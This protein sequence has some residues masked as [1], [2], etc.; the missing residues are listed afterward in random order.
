MN[1][2]E[3]PTKAQQDAAQELLMREHKLADD[4][5]GIMAT[6]GGRRFVWFMLEEFG[7]FK[8]MPVENHAMMAY[9]EGRRNVGLMLISKIQKDC[10][11]QYQVMT[12]ENT[13]K[14]DKGE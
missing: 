14:S 12:N 13:I 3:Q 9:M 4:F 2:Y 11:H 7:A 5:R 8:A 6:E 10:P 1:E